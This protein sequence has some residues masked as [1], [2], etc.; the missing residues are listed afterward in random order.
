MGKLMFQWFYWHLLL[1]GRDI[2]GIPSRM[3]MAGKHPVE[4]ATP[5]RKA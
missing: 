5:Q 1:P 3:S 2:P 4:P